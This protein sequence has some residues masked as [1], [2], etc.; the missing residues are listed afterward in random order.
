MSSE[1]NWIQ[2]NIDIRLAIDGMVRYNAKQ[3]QDHRK[4]AEAILVLHREHANLKAL[5][6]NVE[7]LWRVRAADNTRIKTLEL[8]VGFLTGL[9]CFTTAL[10]IGLTLLAFG[11]WLIS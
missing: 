6:E 8:K 2:E 7:I 10:A 1:P 5:A 9:A 11:W 4:S 3:D